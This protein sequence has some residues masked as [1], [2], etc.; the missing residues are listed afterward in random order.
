[1]DHCRS[2]RHNGGIIVIIVLMVQKSGLT[3]CYVYMCIIVYI[4]MV[5][6]EVRGNAG[7]LIA[8]SLS[9]ES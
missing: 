3:I 1:M 2:S 7:I 9:T 6:T 8:L 5:C 4:Y